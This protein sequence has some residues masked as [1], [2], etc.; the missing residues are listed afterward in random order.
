MDGYRTFKF[1]IKQII[2]PNND[3]SKFDKIYDWTDKNKLKK[4]TPKEV[5]KVH[6]TC[7]IIF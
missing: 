6:S 5:E 7:C 1:K 3:E 2:C 4:E